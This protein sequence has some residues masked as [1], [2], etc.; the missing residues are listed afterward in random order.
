M[1]WSLP[2]LALQGQA[3]AREIWDAAIDLVLPSTCRLCHT[4][5]RPGHDFCP[6]CERPLEVAERMMATTCRQCGRPYAPAKGIPVKGSMVDASPVASSSVEE[7]LTPTGDFVLESESSSSESTRCPQCQKETYEFDEVVSLWPYHDA[8]CEIIVASKY[9]SKVPLADALGRRLGH[10]YGQSIGDVPDLVTFVPSH[11][12][13]QFG[14][15][16][17]SSR[18]I[19]DGFARVLGVKCDGIIKM[20]RQIR[21]QAWLNDTARVENVR[22]A[23]SLVRRIGLRGLPDLTNRHILLVDDVLTTGATA[24]EVSKVLRAGGARRISLATVAR[25]LRS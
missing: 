18:V 8:I 24:N 9:S 12:F 7:N 15:G 13:R 19:G 5:V 20:T 16:G 17:T 25:A 14:R 2:Q 11:V 1:A 22:G 4:A 3:M 10:R 23:F 21:K 6:S